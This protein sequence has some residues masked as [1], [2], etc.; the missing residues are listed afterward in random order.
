MLSHPDSAE[1]SIAIQKPRITRISRIGE[2]TRLGCWRSRPRDRGLLPD[3]VTDHRSLITDHSVREAFTLI[4]LLVVMAIILLMLAALIPAVTSLSKASGRQ[5]GF[6]AL[7]GAI[8]Q[9]RA[10]AIQSAQATYIVFPTFPSG[11]AQSTLDNY[12]FKSY[13]IFED[14]AA[15]P[16]N[17]KQL[18][19]W[20]SLPTGTAL[21]AAA[22]TINGVNVSRLLSYLQDPNTLT[23]VPAFTFTPDLNATTSGFRCI[24]FN[25]NGEVQAPVTTANAVYLGIFEG[26]V[27]NGSEVVTGPK[28]AIGNPF[29]VQYLTISQFTGRAEPAD[30]VA[31]ATP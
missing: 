26:Y 6:N 14:D 18:T 30:A 25:W 5:A 19:G 15:N 20:K 3:L 11:T 7:M 24:K 29:A 27:N 22:Y 4:E 10:A 1:L 13:A 8:E 31:T 2:R 9:A 23:P 21:R 28:D 16:G 17:V 12:N